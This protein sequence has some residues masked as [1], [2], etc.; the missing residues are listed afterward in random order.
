MKLIYTI[1][2]V[3]GADTPVPITVIEKSYLDKDM[4]VQAL[5]HLMTK[6]EVA[7]DLIDELYEFTKEHDWDE[8]YKDTDT[9][10]GIES[11][12]LYE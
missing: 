6:N 9:V 5:A 10:Y 11:N 8:I 2:V 3:Y 12:T 7:P 4:A 1:Y